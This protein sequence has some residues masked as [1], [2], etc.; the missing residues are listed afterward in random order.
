MKLG[1]ISIRPGTTGT[2]FY[3]RAFQRLGIKGSYR[4]LKCE[5][6]N[7][8]KAIVDSGEF[9]GLSISMP[10][11]SQVMVF[12]NDVDPSTFCGESINTMKFMS[13]GRIMGYNTDQAGVEVAVSNLASGKTAILGS[14]SMAKIFS[15]ELEKRGLEFEL[16]SR[17]L[18]NWEERNKTISNLINCT[19]IGMD[20]ISMPVNNLSGIKMIVDLPVSSLEFENRAKT[21]GI[22]Y[23]SGLEFYRHVFLKQLNVYSGKNITK[24]E[25]EEIKKE[26]TERV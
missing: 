9:S 17:K 11:K 20:G 6:L 10:F 19:P 12:C 21:I 3:E 24:Q 14:G 18:G 8:I 26:W 1:S 22:S 25:L 16:Y 5:S 23:F 15:R 7:E 13:D 4:A 2:F